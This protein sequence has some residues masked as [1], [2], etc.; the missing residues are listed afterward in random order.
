L[1]HT[2]ARY[3]CPGIYGNRC[4]NQIIQRCDLL[5]VLGSRLSIMQTGYD[6]S[7]FAKNA[8][9]IMVNTDD[10]DFKGHINIK[11]NC[12][13]IINK[14]RFEDV[15]DWISECD[16]L[17]IQFPFL[18]KEH[19]NSGNYTNSY[20][21]LHDT[22]S[23]KLTDEII[24]TDMGTALIS[25]HNITQLND[26]RMFSSYG[27]GEMGYGLP[28][29]IGAAI[30]GSRVICLNCDGSMMMNLQELQTIKSNNLN[31][32]IIIFNNNGYLSIKH[33]QNMFGHDKNSVDSSSGVE[34][35]VYN[36]IF[37]SFGIN[38]YD[39][40]EEFMSNPGP[41]MFEVFMDPEQYFVPKVQA[42]CENGIVIPAELD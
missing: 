5:I 21:F 31:I 23:P 17:K 15:R 41:S 20:K 12:K 11:M 33:T 6:F 32:K 3:G 34:L 22:L 38:V 37:N 36:R 13:Y 14:L 42:R 40:F 26:N 16:E 18:Q 29:S 39:S 10:T 24:V 30:N 27:L 4:A 28:A 2:L 9:I 19:E 1:K 7:K 8:K 35:P 25:G